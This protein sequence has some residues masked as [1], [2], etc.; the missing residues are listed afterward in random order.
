MGIKAKPFIKWVGGKGQLLEQME[1]LLPADFDDWENTTYIEPF[2]GGG[3]ML[4]NMIQRHPKIKKCV[5]ND[6]N[7]DLIT[8]YRTVRDDVERLIP[9]LM[10]LQKQYCALAD[11]DAKRDMFMAVRQRYNEKDLDP[12]ENTAKFF[13]LNRTCFNG[14]YR[15]NKKGLFNVPY[16]RY[17]NPKICDA[18]TLRADSELLKRVEILEGDFEKTLDYAEGKTLFYFDPPYRPLSDTSNF[19]DYTKEAFNDDSQV[20]LKKFC[21][22]ITALGHS[23]MLSNSDCKGKNE[24]DNFFDVLY[25]QYHVE[26]VMA[27]RNVNSNGAKRGKISELLIHNYSATKVSALKAKNNPV[28]FTNGDKLEGLCIKI[29]TNSCLN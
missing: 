15:V 28:P 6:I 25:A 21:D 23:F 29:L 9:A 24:E 26:R 4:F 14:L 20:R 11:I 12:I 7:H 10:N 22:K 17:I 8:C 2:I 13:F 18:E 27:S 5:I 3:A 19:N 16:G 1:A